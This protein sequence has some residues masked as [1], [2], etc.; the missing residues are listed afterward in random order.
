MTKSNIIWIIGGDRPAT[1]EEHDYRPLWRAM[2]QG[3]DDGMGFHPFMTYHI[4]GGRSTSAEL[5]SETWLDMNMMQSGHGLGQDM[6]VWAMIEHDYVVQ[7]LF[8][9][10][11]VHRFLRTRIS[12]YEYDRHIAGASYA[13]LRGMCGDPDLGW[14]NVSPPRSLVEALDD[15]F[16]GGRS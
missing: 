3:I 13:F 2:A 15:L 9:V 10:V 7:L 11:A 5:H 16:A 4:S 14:C 12:G 1:H 6:P 8:Y